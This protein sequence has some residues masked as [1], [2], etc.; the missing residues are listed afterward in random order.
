MLRSLENELGAEIF[1]RKKGRLTG[2]TEFGENVY[3]LSKR[4]LH[5]AK[6][7]VDMDAD[8]ANHESGRLCI[9]ATHLLARYAVL[10][11]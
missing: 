10:S 9:G 5:D 8:W 7:M 6:R 2:L 4:M 11:T 1:I 3:V